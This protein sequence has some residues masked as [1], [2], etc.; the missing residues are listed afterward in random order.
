MKNIF[1]KNQVIIT[2]LAIMIAVAG[3]LQFTDQ[4]VNNYAQ[5][6]KDTAAVTAQNASVATKSDAVVKDDSKKNTKTKDGKTK[7]KVSSK[8]DSD[9]A[10]ISDADAAQVSDSNELVKN[11]D[12]KD[13]A[14]AAVL[15][16]KTINAD[17]FSEAKLDREQRRASNKKT[18]QALIDDQNIAQNKRN[19]AVDEVINMT[20]ISEKEGATELSLKAKGFEDAVVSIVDNKVE[21]IVNAN[22]LTEQQK[23]QIENIVKM[24]TEIP[25]QNIVITPVEVK[26]AK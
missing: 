10:D 8:K 15:V 6:S 4:K 18:L 26:S 21:V 3:Y 9:V 1:K 2:A 25:I 22:P 19:E 17:F 14:G 5:K 24:K 7:K 23:A 20:S 16:N 12:A 11:S 13:N